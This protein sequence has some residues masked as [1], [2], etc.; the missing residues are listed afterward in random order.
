MIF[1]EYDAGGGCLP[2]RPQAVLTMTR[3]SSAHC[4]A[5]AGT[6]PAPTLQYE[7]YLSL[8]NP[9]AGDI[10]VSI[11]AQLVAGATAANWGIGLYNFDP[12]V[13]DYTTSVPLTGGEISQYYCGAVVEVMLS[14]WPPKMLKC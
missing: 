8:P 10:T 13:D 3:L 4:V 11:T 9:L 1:I 6:P 5:V 14:C 7:V 12:L 2:R